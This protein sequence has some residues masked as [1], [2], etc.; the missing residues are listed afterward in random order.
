[1]FDPLID[2][3]NRKIARAAQAAGMK[4]AI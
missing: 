4:H 1:M 3:Q 2:R